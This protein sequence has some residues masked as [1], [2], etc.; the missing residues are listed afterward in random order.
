MKE[1]YQIELLPPPPPPRKK[2][3][4]KNPALLG[5]IVGKIKDETCGVP[6]EDFVGL[7]PIIYIYIYIYII[8]SHDKI[9]MILKKQKAQIKIYLM[10]FDDKLKH[11]DYK[12]LDFQ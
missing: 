10:I 6:V 11:K 8:Y 9:I 2:L 5:L 1:G 4:W 3:P 12:K 7:K